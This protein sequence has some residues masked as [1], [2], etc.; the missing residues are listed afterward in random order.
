MATR[1]LGKQKRGFRVPL[2]AQNA[3]VVEWQSRQLEV[4]VR[5]TSWGFDSPHSHNLVGWRNGSRAGLRNLWPSGRMGS[6]PMP[7]TG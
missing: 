4:L 1:L 5:E 3:N 7:T 6:I 2:S